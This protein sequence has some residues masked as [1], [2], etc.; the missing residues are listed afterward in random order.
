[1]TLWIYLVVVRCGWM[2]CCGV[3]FEWVWYQTLLCIRTN[4]SNVDLM[5]SHLAKVKDREFLPSFSV[6]TALMDLVTAMVLWLRCGQSPRTG[7]ALFCMQPRGVPTEALC[8]NLGSDLPSWI[9]R[10][11]CI[12]DRMRFHFL[13]SRR[14]MLEG[15]VPVV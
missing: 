3:G 1:M 14:A 10:A 6:R 15:G 2:T 5:Q 8:Y 4:S 11:S 7:Y 13:S 12:V 9:F